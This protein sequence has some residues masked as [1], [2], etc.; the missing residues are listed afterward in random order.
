M[1]DTVTNINS[2]KDAP[3]QYEIKGNKDVVS[4]PFEYYG[5][6][7]L[8][9]HGY[10]NGKKVKFLID[11]GKLWDQVWFYNGEV[12]S[13]NLRYKNNNQHEA[14][15]LGED[16]GSAIIEGTDV[17]ITFGGVSFKNQPSLISPPGAGWQNSFPGVNGQVSSLFFK[18]FIVKFDFENF[19]IV[20]TKP[21][22]FKYSGKGQAIAMHKRDNGSYCI[23]FTLQIAD[24]VIE[25]Y[26]IDIDLGTIFPLHLFENKKMNIDLPANA[27][28]HILGYGGSGKIIGC[29]GNIDKVKIGNYS[30]D[31]VQTEF[32][33]ESKNLSIIEA[34][35][36]GIPL[37]EKFNITFDYFNLKMYIEPNKNY[38]APFTK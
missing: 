24:K 34:G 23:P 22:K 36:F 10:I 7:K 1:S 38:T 4:I 18:H 13:L 28:K 33:E 12:D 37:M 21:D 20:L 3:G 35:T 31:N 25:D 27:E 29:S 8:L 2:C 30:F 26:L 9:I 11:N 14:Q 15:G 16:G 19:V 17:D 32:V 6:K 5:G